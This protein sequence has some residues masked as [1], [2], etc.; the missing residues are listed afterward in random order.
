MPHLIVSCHVQRWLEA[1]DYGCKDGV[2]KW[3]TY[4]SEAITQKYLILYGRDSSQHV[5]KGYY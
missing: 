5:I 2:I 3:D 1:Q 4:Q